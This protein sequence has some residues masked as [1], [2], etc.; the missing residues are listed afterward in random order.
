MHS[1]RTSPPPTLLLLGVPLREDADTVAATEGVVVDSV[2]PL[3][4]EPSEVFLAFDAVAEVLL[5]MVFMLKCGSWLV[6]VPLQRASKQIGH[7]W[8][9]VL[10][11]LKY[12]LLP[13]LPSRLLLF[14]SL[15]LLRHY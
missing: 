11:G 7:V 1:N 5:A 10:A 8:C 3:S 15:L 14:L 13:L 6:I 12:L 9:P 4:A 2:C